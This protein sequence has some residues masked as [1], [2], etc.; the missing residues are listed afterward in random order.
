MSPRSSR[1]TRRL[2]AAA[3]A[4]AAGI[5]LAG[6]SQVAALAPVGGDRITSLRIAAVDVLLAEGVQIKVTPVCETG[7][8][9]YTCEGS[10]MSG[11]TISVTGPVTGD[12]TMV[13]KV[14]DRTVYDGSVATVLEQNA[15]AG[16]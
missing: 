11:D 4:G 12:L 1:G 14:G 10:T 9:D 2:A 5:L 8:T 6:C 13:V 15:Q 7:T 3:L 16:S